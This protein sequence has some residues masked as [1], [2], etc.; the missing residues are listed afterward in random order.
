MEEDP[1]T[2]AGREPGGGRAD[3]PPDERTLAVLRRYAAGEISARQASYEMGGDASEHD[4]YVQTVRAGL[5]IP[6]PPP[7]VIEAE[8][9]ALRRLYFGR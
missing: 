5:T 9:A 7:E 1:G 2:E 4:V 8:V 3:H 6:S